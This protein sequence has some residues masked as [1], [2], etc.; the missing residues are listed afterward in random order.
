MK[1]SLIFKKVITWRAISVLVTLVIMYMTTGDVKSA[2][3]VTVLLQAIL[4][5][6]H[7]TFEKAW[8]RIFREGDK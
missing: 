7:Y 2:T 5:C 6:C 4:V 1:S 8:D 3:G